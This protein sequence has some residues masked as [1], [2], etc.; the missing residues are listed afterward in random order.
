[1]RIS[2]KDITVTIG[3]ATLVE[4]VSLDV[5]P[6]SFTGL[7]GPNGSGKTTLLKTIYRA[8]KPTRGTVS[9]DGKD[10][11]DLSIRETARHIAVMTQSNSVNFDFTIEEMVLTG[12]TPHKRLLE[13]DKEADRALVAEALERVGL[14]AFAKRKF[15]TLSGGE[16]QRVL[17]ARALTQEPRVLVLDEPTNHLDI[18]HQ[19]QLVTLVQSLGLTTIMAMHDLNLAA[20]YCDTVHMMRNGRLVA[21]GP[22]SEVFTEPRLKDVFRVD[23]RIVD[24]EGIGHKAIIYI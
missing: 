10:I 9:I 5:A 21:S 13:Q 6:G 4:G 23:A 19:L 3:A 16:R 22:P 14:A 18:E 7:V 15:N 20:R 17:I 2:L 24:I 11:A 1:M 12:R 8:V